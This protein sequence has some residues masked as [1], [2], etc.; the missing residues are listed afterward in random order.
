M[1]VHIE[2]LP[3]ADELPASFD[4]VGRQPYAGLGYAPADEPAAELCAQLADTHDIIFYTDHW[5][6]RLAGLFPKAGGAVAFFAFWETA[7]ALLLNQLAFD[8]LLADAAARGF[9][10]VQGPLHFSTCFRYRLRLGAAPSWRQFDRE[11]VNPPYY[12]GLLA[13]LGFQP[14]LTFESHRLPAAHL[15]DVPAGPEQLLHMEVEFIPLTSA[16]WQELEDEILELIQ[17]VLRQNPAYHTVSKQQ[18]QLLYNVNYADGLC[19]YASGLFR[20]RPSGRLVAISLCRPNYHEL[21]RAIRAHAVYARDY[22]HLRTRTLL[23]ELVGVHPDFHGQGLQTLLAAY[24]MQESKAH[25]DDVIFCL[26]LADNHSPFAEGSPA[27]VAH[28]A[29]FERTIHEVQGTTK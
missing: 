23:V 25:Y 6:L 19:P 9:G 24:A 27:E 20:H 14:V 28:Y 1:S 5:N 21:G 3:Y 18:L 8:Q 2:R 26:T 4:I 11:P 7:G 29:L 10:T 16:V 12:P 15:P 17:Q 22:P 13:E